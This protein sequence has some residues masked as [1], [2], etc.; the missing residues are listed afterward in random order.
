M[1]PSTVFL[2]ALSSRANHLLANSRGS[3]ID[4]VWNATMSNFSFL[5]KPSKRILKHS[6][7]FDFIAY[8]L[9]MEEVKAKAIYPPVVKHGVLENGPLIGDFPLKPLFVRDFPLPCLMKPE[10]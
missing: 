9:L 5:N 8:K 4:A 10:G 1:F 6:F 3:S 7:L 2:R